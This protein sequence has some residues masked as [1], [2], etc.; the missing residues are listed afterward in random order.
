MRH[1]FVTQSAAVVLFASLTFGIAAASGAPQ[2]QGQRKA[3]GIPSKRGVY[4]GCYLKASGALRVVRTSRKCKRSERR[5]TWNRVGGR[6][7]RGQAG[8]QGAAGALGLVGPSG[9]QGATGPAGPTGAQGAIGP[10]GSAGPAGS[11]GSQGVQ[12]PEGPEGPAGP[13]VAGATLVTVRVPASGF[14]TTSPKV[15]TA[16]CAV[17][18]TALGGGYSLERG[19]LAE[20]D[21]T[22]L[23]TLYSKPDAGLVGWTSS[24]LEA[25][26]F[27][28]TWA[29][30]AYAICATVG[31]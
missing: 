10:A 15:A 16:S 23:A 20:S 2:A 28:E 14:D 4:A 22:K 30:S 11:Q 25:S 24:A 8:P 19:T 17:G 7:A 9:S 6:G 13:G 5:V 29:L 26:T 3:A 1:R 18:E 31:P 12:G 21:L 27:G